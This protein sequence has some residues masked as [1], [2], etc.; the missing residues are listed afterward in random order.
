MLIDFMLTVSS[1]VKEKY[2]CRYGQMEKTRGMIFYS[3][4]TVEKAQQVQCVIINT[5]N[6]TQLNELL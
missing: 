4:C 3:L 1:T 2:L 6:N 5:E